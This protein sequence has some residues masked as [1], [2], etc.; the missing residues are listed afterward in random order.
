[1]PKECWIQRQKR[2]EETVARYA[3]KRRALKA[4]KDYA[5][6]AALPRDA[7]PVRLKN[8]CQVTGRAHSY[9]QKYGISRITFRE[10]AH[11]AL[12]PGIT[13]SSW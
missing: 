11:Q 10:L 13:K 6:L 2:R 1:M 5:G 3:D 9:M 8:R 4:A 12:I 7:S